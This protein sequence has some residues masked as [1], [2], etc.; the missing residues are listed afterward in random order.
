MAGR[1]CNSPRCGCEYLNQVDGYM[2][3]QCDFPQCSACRQYIVSLYVNVCPVCGAMLGQ[4]R[5]V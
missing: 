2:C 4:P 1:R 5:H 3:P